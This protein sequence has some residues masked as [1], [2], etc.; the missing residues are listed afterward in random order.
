MVS[1]LGQGTVKSQ[2]QHPDS[3][4]CNSGLYG[5]NVAALLL[6]ITFGVVISVGWCLEGR[7]CWTETSKELLHDVFCL[8]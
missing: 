6:I 8:V 2:F 7:N 4:K 1:K 3:R 5:N